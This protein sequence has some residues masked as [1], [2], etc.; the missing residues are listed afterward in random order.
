MTL[1][2]ERKCNDQVMDI[3]SSSPISSSSENIAFCTKDILVLLECSSKKE[4][5]FKTKNSSLKFRSLKFTSK[6]LVMAE[7]S[8]NYSILT[9]K[10]MDS[11]SKMKEIIIK[12]EIITI[13]SSKGDYIAYGTKKG[14]IGLLDS[15][16]NFIIKE[17]ER[18]KMLVTTL[19]IGFNGHDVY[20]V[21][22]S[23]CGDVM[24]TTLRDQKK[25]YFLLYTILFLILSIIFA[26]WKSH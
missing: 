19:D 11:K 5:I 20:V 3:A 17:R 23:V 24:V 18:H 13:L 26:Y 15:N 10:P 12:D 21:S 6:H 14:S 25:Y 4:S 16:G 22:G 8:L 1:L 9:F 7:C 2:W